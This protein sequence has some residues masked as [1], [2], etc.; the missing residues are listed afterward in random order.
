MVHSK[1]KESSNTDLKKRIAI[2]EK[3]Q[4]SNFI[5]WQKKKY[6]EALNRIKFK[7]ENPNILDVGCGTGLQIEIFL[8][9]F[10]KCSILATDISSNSLK[11]AKQKFK[12][13]NVIFKKIDMDLIPKFFN[14]KKKINFDL[15]HSSY[16]LYYSKNPK[17]LLNNFSK[18]LNSGGAMI[19]SSPDEPHEMVN[20]VKKNAVVKKKVLN[21]LKFYKKTLLPFMLNKMNKK[22]F[23][24]IKKVNYLK[25]NKQQDFM[26]F[27]R[28]TTYYNKKFENKILI[29]LKKTS[30]KFKKISAIAAFKKS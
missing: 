25:F 2:N 22:N 21:T 26:S 30:L 16:A 6:F 29:K 13:K 27:W 17:K 7:K 11:Q 10:K 23:Y 4:K 19:I 18:Y 20:F 12:N 1:Y 8:K 3:F 14:N 28:S 24:T 9:K 15:I 5:D